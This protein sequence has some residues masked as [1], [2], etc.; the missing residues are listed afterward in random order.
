MKIDTFVRATRLGYKEPCLAQV[1]CQKKLESAQTGHPYIFIHR[2][3]AKT[4]HLLFMLS[5]M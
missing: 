4:W 2:G 1:L 3:V 5:K